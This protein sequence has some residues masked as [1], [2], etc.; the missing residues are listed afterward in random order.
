M[1]VSALRG[2]KT[3]ERKS[4]SDHISDELRQMIIEG[5]L[6]PGEQLGEARIAEQLG[7]SRA[8]V[9]EAL[10]QLVQ[11]K[12]LVAARNKGVSV[13]TFSAADIW[14]IYDARCAIESHAAVRI[15]DGG[16][17]SRART[18]DELRAALGSLRTAVKRHDHRQISAADLDFHKTLVASAGNSRL[19]DAYDILSAQALACINRLEIALPSGEEVIDDHEILIAAIARGDREAI[20]KAINDHLSVA[21]GHLTAPPARATENTVQHD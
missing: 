20:I 11:Q 5:A 1:A 12:L 2:L 9:R 7:V 13:V 16:P 19:V 18:T 4:T 15:L 3:L 10:Q 21:A 14:E 8:P 17:G 6:G